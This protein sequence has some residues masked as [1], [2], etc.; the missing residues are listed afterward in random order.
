[1]VTTCEHIKSNGEPCGSPALKDRNFC[2]FH[3]RFH[4]LNDIPG[5][6]DY[7]MPALED[8]LSIQLFLMQI[9]HAQTCGSISRDTATSMLALAKAAMSNL[10]LARATKK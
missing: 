1:M 3:D 9:G 6:P 10:R 4:D 2:H 8:H 7:I 5:S